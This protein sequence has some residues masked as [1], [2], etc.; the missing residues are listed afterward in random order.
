M[1][2]ASTKNCYKS[3]EKHILGDADNFPVQWKNKFDVVILAGLLNNNHLEYQLIEEMIMTTKQNGLIVFSARYSMM[4][5]YWYTFYLKEL[6][7]EGR[8][9]LIKS[10]EYFKYTTLGTC[11][12]RFSKTP[13]KTYAYKNLCPEINGYKTKVVLDNT[14]TA[15]PKDVKD[16]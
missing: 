15:F 5:N 9:K 8:I 13:C 7:A 12:G 11:V 14:F 4:G 6:E 3:L 2:I 10:K 16:S 1:D